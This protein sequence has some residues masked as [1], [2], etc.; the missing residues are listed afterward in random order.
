MRPLV[1]LLLGGALAGLPAC[2]G[3]DAVAPVAPPP[4]A[5]PVDAGP[6]APAAAATLLEAVGPVTVTRG[7]APAPATAGPLFDGDVL[8]TGEAARAVVRLSDGRTLELSENGRLEVDASNDGLVLEV[9]QGVVVTRERTGGDGPTVQLTLDTPYGLVRV[10]NAGLSVSV[11]ASE[12]GVDVLAGEV[13]LVGREGAALELPAGA[14]GTLGKEG[15][16]RRVTLEPLTVVISSGAGRIEVKKKGAR[17][18]IAVNP[19]KPPALAPGDSVRVTS[20]SAT[21]APAD[22]D[23]RV[24]LGAGTEVGVGESVKA[25]GVEDLGLELKKGQ[26]A[27]VLP[28]GKKRTLRPGNGATLVAEQGGQLS[29]VR[30]RNGL[31]L[32]SVAGDVLVTLDGGGQTLVKGG[33]TATVTNDQVTAK[34]VAREALQLP[35]HPGLRLLH[36]GAERVALVWSPDEDGPVRFTLGTEPSLARPLVDGVLHQA[37]FNTTAPARGVLHWRVTRGE[38]EVAKGSVACAPEKVGD[39]LGG[40]TNEVPAGP[41]KTV[42]FFQD[43]PP[44]LTFIWKAPDKP[45]A[46]YQ[47]KV[48]RAGQLSAPLQERTVTSTTAQLPL[49]ALGEGQ[50]QW[51]VTWLD[52]KGTPIG[53]AGKMNQ[54]ELNYDNAV[55]ALVIKSP[56][57]GDPPAPKV[58]VAGIAPIGIKVTAN[59]QPVA[60]DAKARFSGS[61]TPLPG[62]RVV[63]RAQQEGADTFIVRWLGGRGAR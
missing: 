19:K 14:A 63:F 21:L 51:D 54:L 41:E 56:R 2:S 39:E 47:L 28:F 43:K 61:V 38:R 48:Y 53:T 42:I 23:A 58:A 32:N 55:R 33:Q 29:V 9:G 12:A 11:G 7:G 62:A 4:A 8:E 49:G 30:G 24:T 59:G 6:P 22:G 15:A 60:L 13:T 37:F 45:V 25:G 16:S 18:Y 31:E 26:L 20:G 44:A 3:P 52:A 27:V 5:R 57:N 1:S 40:I 10:G 50:Y 17:A 36:P 35:S 46:S 34:D